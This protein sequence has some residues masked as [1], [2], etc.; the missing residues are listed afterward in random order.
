MLMRTSIFEGGAMPAYETPSVELLSAETQSI[1]CNSANVE[2][3]VD[4]GDVDWF[5]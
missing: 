2:D 3:F 1:L 5:N 4:N